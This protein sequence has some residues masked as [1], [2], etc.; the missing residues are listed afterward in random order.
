MELEWWSPTGQ[1]LFFWLHSG[2]TVSTVSDPSA[3]SSSSFVALQD[4]LDPMNKDDDE[5][6]DD[7]KGD[8]YD[9]EEE[10]EVGWVG[11]PVTTARLVA[12]VVVVV[13]VAVEEEEE[14]NVSDG[15]I[16][17]AAG[18][19]NNSDEVDDDVDDPVRV[20]AACADSALLSAG[21][22][23]A[24]VDDDIFCLRSVEELIGAELGGCILE[25]L[26]IL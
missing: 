5:E 26:S 15:R 21:V 10:E 8:G 20:K 25:L 22:D 12:R 24:E 7:E 16:D 11:E 17:T 3:A 6:E 4:W 14:G 9:P 13:L 1:G 23:N 18:C 2:H 19:D